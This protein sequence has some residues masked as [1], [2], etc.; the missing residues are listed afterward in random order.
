MTCFNV[1][2]DL[3]YQLM[4]FDV[5]NV[6]VDLP[7]T[8]VEEYEQIRD[9]L[10]ANMESDSKN[11]EAI[12]DAFQ[13]G[14][15]LCP[16]ENASDIWHHII[17]RSYLEFYQDM[18]PPTSNA[19]QSWVRT[20]GDALELFFV[21]YYNQR[22]PDDLRMTALFGSAEGRALEIMDIA[23]SVG[24]AKLDITIEGK[25]QG[26]WHIFGGSHSKA[27]LAE[28][29]TD[30]VPASEV[31]ME[32]GFLSV[33]QTMDVK[34]FPPNHGGDLVNNGE[35]GEPE[36]PSEKRRY[37]EDLGQFSDLYSYNER[38]TPS[39]EQTASGS[40]I[41]TISIPSDEDQFIRDCRTFWNTFKNREGISNHSIPQGIGWNS[42]KS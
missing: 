23:D 33:M 8:T 2:P 25:T 21:D 37:V 18:N 3:V 42:Q 5:G 34:S 28:R 14:V 1:S 26:E 17:Y 32:N 13:F 39:P 30:D 38:T 31:M 4:E 41:V 10:R 24:E 19:N 36:S 20:S 16:D 6:T 7:N 9:R 15:E 35:L 12:K 27:S 29:V 40:Q 22:L 11:R